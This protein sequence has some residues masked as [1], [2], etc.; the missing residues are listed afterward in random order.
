MFR[1]VTY[2]NPSKRSHETPCA[3]GS[4]RWKVSIAQGSQYRYRTIPMSIDVGDIG[5]ISSFGNK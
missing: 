5:S 3:E 4:E 1:P 2:H